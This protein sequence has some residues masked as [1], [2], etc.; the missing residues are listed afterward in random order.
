M[1]FLH[2]IYQEPVGRDCVP[3]HNFV[4]EG[5]FKNAVCCFPALSDATEAEAV[6]AVNGSRVLQNI[7]AYGANHFFLKLT[8]KLLMGHDGAKG[9][10]KSVG[11]REISCGH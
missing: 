3:L 11:S 6:P 10:F 1:D 7:Q 8:G 5:T 9:F 2:Q 4:A